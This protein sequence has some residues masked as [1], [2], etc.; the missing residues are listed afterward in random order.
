M[1]VSGAIRQRPSLPDTARLNRPPAPGLRGSDSN[2]QSARPGGETAGSV[3][4]EVPHGVARALSERV[5][6]NVRSGSRI[7][8]DEATERIVVQILNAENEVIKQIPPDD[9]LRVLERFRQVTGI[10]FDRQV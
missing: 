2:V 10:L 8:I 5:A 3:L 6:A 1:E 7:R 9:L 4:E